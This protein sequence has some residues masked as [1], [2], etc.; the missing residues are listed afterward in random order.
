M[1]DGHMSFVNVFIRH[2]YPHLNFLA[3]IWQIILR[4]RDFFPFF[5]IEDIIKKGVPRK[6]SLTL[7]IICHMIEPL[8]FYFIKKNIKVV[9][10]V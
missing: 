7:K 3:H 10:N 1:S 8:K 9:E 4:G 2:L 6:I 5:D